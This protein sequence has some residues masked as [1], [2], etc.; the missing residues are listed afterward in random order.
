MTRREDRETHTEAD[1]AAWER[2]HAEPDYNPDEPT[3]AEA[4]TDD[5]AMEEWWGR[6]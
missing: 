2:A 6:G 4:E 1:A 3:R 5:A